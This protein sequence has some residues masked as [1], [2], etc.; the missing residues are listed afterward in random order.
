MDAKGN[1][2]PSPSGVIVDVEKV[3][4]SVFV[5]VGT[6]KGIQPVKHHEVIGNRFEGR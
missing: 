5:L 1:G 2:A 3:K 4:P 6:R